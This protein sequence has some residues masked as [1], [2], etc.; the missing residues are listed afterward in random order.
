VVNQDLLEDYYDYLL[1]IIGFNQPEHRKYGRLLDDLFGIPFKYTL[2][3]DQNRDM[4]G[5]YLRKEFLFDVGLDVNRDIWYDDRSVLEVLIAFSRRIETEITGEPGMDDYGRWFWK[6]LKNLDI[7]YEDRRYDHGLVRHKLDIWMCRK[8]ERSGSGG[9]FPLKKCQVDQREVE[10][11]YQMQAYL[12]EN[13][14]F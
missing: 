9:L 6:M 7:L 13:W 10:M 12:N 11:W 14:T 8:F 1:D 3:M 5:L 4:D 2:E